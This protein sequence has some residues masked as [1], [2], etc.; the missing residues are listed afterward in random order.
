M[1]PVA[2]IALASLALLATAC[3]DGR[4]EEGV[5]SMEGGG[6]YPSSDPAQIAPEG[7]A[8]SASTASD[9]ST[10]SVPVPNAPAGGAITSD[11]GDEAQKSAGDAGVTSGR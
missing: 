10:K 3:G 2:P 7:V 1:K 6:V 4:K 5:S 9:V 11:K 8:P